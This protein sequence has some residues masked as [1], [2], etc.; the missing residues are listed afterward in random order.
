MNVEPKRIVLGLVG[1]Q[2][3]D[4]AFTA[5]PNQWV[6]DDLARLGFPLRFR[7]VLPTIKAA[8]AAGLFV[9][10]RWPRLGRLTAY[11]LVAY[12]VIALGFHARAKDNVIRYLPAA[13]MLGW[14]ALASRSFPDR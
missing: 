4:A 8:S 2:L 1:F 7:T 12:F 11:L 9:G 13:G 14:A 10:L 3:L 5:V 6:R